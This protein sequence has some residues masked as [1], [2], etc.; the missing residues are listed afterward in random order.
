MPR[1]EYLSEF[2]RS[3]FLPKYKITDRQASPLIFKF[4]SMRRC[5]RN[6]L[7]HRRFPK[8]NLREYLI[9]RLVTILINRLRL[10]LKRLSIIDI[11]PFHLFL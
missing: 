8:K 5:S 7:A 4:I 6:S 11:I 10:F 3:Q 9:T 1:H 2:P